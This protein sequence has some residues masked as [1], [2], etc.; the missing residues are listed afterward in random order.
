VLA[1][2]NE[3]LA[4]WDVSPFDGILG[5]GKKQLT[6]LNDISFLSRI[7]VSRFTMCLSNRGGRL[8]F[9]PTIPGLTAPRK[10]LKTV[11]Q[12]AWATELTHVGV[13]AK[14]P[15]GKAAS[16]EGANHTATRRADDLRAK[17]QKHDVSVSDGAAG[18][19]TCTASK[20]C[21]LIV[22]SG[23]TM[24]TVPAA[25]YKT[26]LDGID[27]SCATAGC[28]DRVAEQRECS[29]ADFDGLPT[30]SF[31]LG[32][33]DIELP[34]TAYMAKM[35]V[36]MPTYTTLGPFVIQQ[37]GEGE[38][39]VPLFMAQD[40]PT[41]F[42]PLV[43]FGMPFLR[44]FATTFDRAAGELS[45]YDLASAPAGLCNACDSTV[46]PSKERSVARRNE[47][48]DAQR[49]KRIRRYRQQL[50]STRKSSKLAALQ[51]QLGA[52]MEPGAFDGESP[53]DVIRELAGVI[54]DVHQEQDVGSDNVDGPSEYEAVMSKIAGVI[55]NALGKEIAGSTADAAP[56]IDMRQLRLPWWS[57]APSLRPSHRG[58]QRD[59]WQ[60]SVTA[61]TLPRAPEEPWML[62]L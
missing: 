3:A 15:V 1:V 11:G 35:F 16:G 52:L 6:D 20:P 54:D 24:M 23:T 26:L 46:K 34:P 56:T 7:N 28:L 33:V 38:R 30:L 19:A 18:G 53:A 8:Q 44:A 50:R 42:G 60:P 29:G 45:I 2:A 25:L 48:L 62:M 13:K 10:A 55:E 27:A 47:Q 37:Y 4:N 40:T 49:E 58:L 36:D 39:C 22:D 17:N 9:G 51:E 59:R 12:H 5:L 32:G 61:Q 14:G 57:V 31:T 41:N 21:G 43:I